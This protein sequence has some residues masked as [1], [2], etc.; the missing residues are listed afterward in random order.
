MIPRNAEDCATN[1]SLAFSAETTEA[2]QQATNDLFKELF[3]RRR[4]FNK[5]NDLTLKLIFKRIVNF[6]LVPAKQRRII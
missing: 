4:S 6:A 3:W 1:A 2:V 5:I